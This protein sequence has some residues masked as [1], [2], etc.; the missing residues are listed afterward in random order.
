MK[1]AILTFQFAHNYGAQLQTYALK[2]FVE[3]MGYEV[4][5]APYY[6]QHFYADYE[7]NPF[8]AGIPL[9]RRIRILLSYQRRKPQAKRFSAFQQQELQ[10]SKSILKEQ[11][12]VAYLNSCDGVIFGGDQIW[13]TDLTGPSAD[14][15]FGRGVKVPHIAYAA[16]IGTKMLTTAQK[17]LAESQLPEFAAVSLREENSRQ[18]LALSTNQTLQVVLDPVFLIPTAQWKSLAEQAEIR[19]DTPYLLL[20]LLRENDTLLAYAKQYAKQNQLEIVEIHPTLAKFH[21]GTRRLEQVGPYEFLYLISHAECVC[22]NSFHATSFSIVFFKK[23]IHIPNSSSPDRTKSLLERIGIQ[24]VTDSIKMPLY[25]PEQY[26]GNRMKTMIL[27]SK[28]FLTK[29]LDELKN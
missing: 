4:E 21:R 11:D 1:I 17:K 8:A 26:D 14:L 5:V 27:E 18:M 28:N 22:T 16:S 6:P 29:S 23:L 10:L 20:Y 7:L 13:N 19:Q 25:L 2:K 3:S 9:R 15:Y 24:L 12:A